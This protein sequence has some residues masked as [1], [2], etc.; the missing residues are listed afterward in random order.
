MAVEYSI[1]TPIFAF[2]YY[3]NHRHLYID[4][5]TGKKD[6][7]KIK[8][9][10]K[11]LFAV[12]S[13][14]DV[15]YIV[16]RIAAQYQLLQQT[17]LEPFE[18]SLISSVVAWLSFFILVNITMNVFDRFKRDEFFWFCMLVLSMNIANSLILFS[19][20]QARVFYTNACADITAGIALF[21]ALF[22]IY[23]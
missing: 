23:K 17:G 22:V 15:M 20:D 5:I 12:F 19:D 9:D 4:S 3:R 7:S 21:S 14:T 2:L 6:T 16:V 10:V 1:D 8:N 11:K 13:I 18:A